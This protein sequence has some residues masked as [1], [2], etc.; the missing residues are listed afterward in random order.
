MPSSETFLDITELIGH[1]LR[2]GIQRVERELI[3][4]WP[5]PSRLVLCVFDPI[6]GC[7][8]VV[9][10]IAATILT[11]RSDTSRLAVAQERAALQALLQGEAPVPVPH[12]AGP[13]V[14]AELFFEPRRV[15]FYESLA[16]QGRR[17]IF[18]LVYD[19]LPFLEPRWF[20]QGTGRAAMPY[21]RALRRMPRVAFI[22]EHT[23]RDY[24]HRVMRSTRLDGPVI[25][26]GGDGLQLETQRFGPERDGYVA[27]GSLEP[28]KRVAAVLEAFAAVWAQGSR[29]RLTLIGRVLPHARREI[30]LLNGLEEQGLLQHLPDASDATVREALRRARALIFASEAEGFGLPPFEALYCGIPVVVGPGVP[31]VEMLPPH[32]QIRLDRVTPDSIAE[33]V[34]G[35]QD[36]ARAAR[37]WEDVGLLDV[38][39]W[40]DFAAA[41]AKWVHAPAPDT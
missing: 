8:R 27:L 15:S 16:Q 31:S 41:L 22:S 19:F 7:L 9:P 11:A 28:R 14:N 35:L 34:R 38:P 18:W 2:T 1:P 33:A 32:G 17:D 21:L 25:V 39:A 13:V 12:G 30:A 20:E 10:D 23:R 29:A 3:R 26:L 4:H 5:G 37:L 36:D 40:R 6:P 24:L